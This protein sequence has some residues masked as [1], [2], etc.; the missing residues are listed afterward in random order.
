M[1][2]VTVGGITGIIVFRLFQLQIAQHGYYVAL[3][4]DQHQLQKTLLPKRGDILVYDKYS[5][6]PYPLA[7]NTETTLVYAV[8]REMDQPTLAAHELAPIFR[9]VDKRIEDAAAKENAST[10]TT[11]AQKAADAE[12]AKNKPTEEELTMK[13]EA[14]LTNE[15]SNHDDVYVPLKH[16]VDDDLIDEIK[17]LS[18]KGIY[19]QSEESRIYPEGQL[20]G[21]VLGYVTLSDQD[22]KGQYGIEGYYESLLKGSA[23]RLAVDLD[24]NGREITVGDKSLQQAQDGTNIVLT[25]DHSIQFEA[26]QLLDDAVKKHGATGGSIIV[27]DPKTGKILALANYPTFDPNYYNLV[28]D[29]NRL[30]DPAVNGQYEPGSVFKPITMAAAL[31]TGAITPTATYD[32]TGS[33][34]IGKYTIK[35]A[36]PGAHGTITMTKALEQSYNTGAIYAE[37]QLGKDKFKAYVQSLGFGLPTGIELSGEAV[38][39]IKN[40]DKQSDVNYAT[41]SFGQGIAVT[42]LQLITAYTA[43]AN[44]GKLMQPHIVD[45]F[46]KPDGSIQ[47]VDPTVVGQVFSPATASTMSA[48]MVSVV[49]NGL[50]HQA[51]V[52]GYYVAGKTGTAQI[53]NPD[54]AGYISGKTIGTFVGFAPVDNPQFLMLVKIDKPTDVQFAESNAAPLFGQMAAYLL[55]YLQV[56][57]SRPTK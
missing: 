5:S 49:E 37:E 56:P 8:P 3:A 13:I 40:L 29:I 21:Q 39:D 1:L 30:S 23:G 22:R 20:A 44:G 35:N 10:I 32:D 26:E 25:I 45:R 15:L 12:A 43:I 41:A 16:R 6:T 42:P 9:E 50:G 7:T 28:D 18:L 54:G 53:P 2:M 57:P 51:K 46:I 19:F 4:N 33:V 24:A 36:E 11:D 52:P 38:G 14:D 31:D 27:E 48:M 17:K 47:T 55:N 34:T